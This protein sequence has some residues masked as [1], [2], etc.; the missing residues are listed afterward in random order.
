MPTTTD[1]LNQLEQD[2]EDL[3]DNLETKGIIGLTGDETFTEL[4]P[5]VLNIPSGGGNVAHP[6]YVSFRQYP[7]ATLDISWLR[8]DNMTGF[9]NM[10]SMCTALTGVDTSLFQTSHITSFASMFANCA[11]FAS[12]NFNF[13]ITNATTLQS[14]FSGCSNMQTFTFANNI[15]TTKSVSLSDMF[16]FC[17]ALETI[18]LSNL[19]TPN[20]DSLYQMFA[21]CSNLTSVNFGNNTYNAVTSMNGMFKNCTSLQS[22]VFPTTEARLSQTRDLFSGCTSLVTADLSKFMCSYLTNIRSMFSNCTA[23]ETVDLSNLEIAGNYSVYASDMFNNCT[24][25]TRLDMRKYNFTRVTT[26]TNMFTN[27]PAN[28]LIIVA[29]TTQKDWF[30]TKFPNLTNVKTVAEL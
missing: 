2:R 13:D 3:V 17:S 24:S 19:N 26:S 9:D 12:Y 1:Y 22:I 27:V 29:D 30:A 6:S 11:Q 10:F 4:V 14:M 7:G 8:T 28:C 25:L 16:S 20:A 23:L 18:D 21:N 5:E 15:S